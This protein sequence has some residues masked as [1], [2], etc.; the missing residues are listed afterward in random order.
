MA[1]TENLFKKYGFINFVER[2][3][4]ADEPYAKFGSGAAN[5]DGL[6]ISD[7]YTKTPWVI[8]LC[9]D[10]KKDI[11]MY[12]TE[13]KSTEFRN[14]MNMKLS[15][16]LTEGFMSKL[17]LACVYNRV[18]MD[19]GVSETTHADEKVG[20][21]F[22]FNGDDYSVLYEMDYNWEG[23][24]TRLKNLGLVTSDNTI[25]RPF[26]LGR[27]YHVSQL[28]YS[29]QSDKK[30]FCIN[31]VGDAS[32]R[33]QLSASWN[34]KAYLIPDTSTSLTLTKAGTH[35]TIVCTS[36][37]TIAGIDGGADIT[38]EPGRP[39]KLTSDSRTVNAGRKG[40][41]FHVWK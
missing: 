23:R 8:H 5:V 40:I 15:Q 17:S 21:L 4:A 39:I 16:A 22:T 41:I 37:F 38:V 11:K 7:Y 35:D 29:Q 10:G 32:T 31:F 6:R 34:S 1:T 36:D 9:N 26:Q 18:D 33:D 28:G 25:T 3:E 27:P 2:W 12:Y 30:A 19:Y 14:L 20:D 24:L 13:R